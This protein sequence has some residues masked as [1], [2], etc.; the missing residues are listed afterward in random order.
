MP[1]LARLGNRASLL[2]HRLVY[3][4]PAAPPPTH[5]PTSAPDV[6]PNFDPGPAPEPAPA[7]SFMGSGY[8]V[9]LILMGILLNRIHHTV[10]RPRQPPPNDHPLPHNPSYFYRL[11]TSVSNFFTSPDAP[12]YIRLPGIVC[13]LRAWILFTVVLIQ[14]L[15][16]WPELQHDGTTAMWRKAAN[17]LGNWADEMEM[18]DIC[19][20]V[21]VSVCV[22]LLC[23]GI[24]NGLD[25]IRRRDVAAS[26]NLTG[27][28]FM[29][30][31]YSS[32]LTHRHTEQAVAH[33]R[34][35]IHA[36]FQLWLSL[37]ELTWLQI[38]ELSLALR[39]NVLLPT[40][41]C[42]IVGVVHFAYV[43]FSSPLRFPSF[44]FLT[45]ML[46]LFLSVVILSTIILRAITFIFSYGY[47]P[48]LTSLLP[49]EGVIP[50]RRDD[51]GVTLLK[52]GTA[53]IEATS[54][55]GL[56]NELASADKPREPWVEI[57]SDGS[58]F[59][60]GRFLQHSPP[61]PGFSTEINHIKVSEAEDSERLNPQWREV[62]VFARALFTAI[63]SALVQF[64]MSTR[65]G[66]SMFRFGKKM[67]RA[68]WWY[69]PR[70][71][72]FW[73]REAWREPSEN[74][75]ARARARE[76]AR[77]RARARASAP[78]IE[79][80]SGPGDAASLQRSGYSTG[81]STSVGLRGH[82]DSIT[83]I[84]RKSQP[85]REMWTYADYLLK[86]V[87]VEIEDDGEWVQEVSDDSDSD[88]EQMS[89]ADVNEEEE[90]DL[91][92]EGLDLEE[93]EEE[94]KQRAMLYGDLVTQ[95]TG[96]HG[97][98]STDD[99]LQPVLLAHLTSRTAAPLTRQ[100]YT[101]LMTLYSSDSFH[102]PTSASLVSVRNE[103]V[104]A[105]RDVMH[106][107][108]QAMK[109]YQEEDEETKSTCVVCM[110][111]MRDT[112]LWPCRCLA[113][114]NDC[115]ETLAARL[116]AQNHM[117]PVEGYSRIYIP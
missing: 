20:Q 84:Q 22:G 93:E 70:S 15:G 114:C 112:I 57:T 12:R 107:R 76:L 11:R 3:A 23:S 115:R 113:V 14:V 59:H 30:H 36:V 92:D 40:S 56:R 65:V 16:L 39:D 117:C 49:H 35:D 62:R 7:L 96:N 31:L 75:R 116:P 77:A 42:G 95:T 94:V 26:F 63:L 67:W 97:R 10:R 83:T 106:E 51:F 68:R 89:I 8:G 33:R 81:T 46:A 100:R 38:L 45:H 85:K 21:F 50:D 41:V 104:L 74:I 66:R 110:V 29:M 18:N 82:D 102:T 101:S 13:L 64:L 109:N 87:D 58:Q 99:D 32:P 108:R 6:S 90:D 24:A 1:L 52:I 53:C 34:P 19:W 105:L 91:T 111:S 55:S 48:S 71:W 98:Q 86:D 73:R 47:I 60:H 80:V 2:L 61:T 25:T 54:F 44:T 9:T 72:K 43:L 88:S 28:S 4:F 103:D 27:Y 79:Q 17:R 69:G 37:T 5:S 78:T